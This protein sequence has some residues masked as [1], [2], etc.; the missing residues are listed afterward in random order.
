M[1]H[2]LLLTTVMIVAFLIFFFIAESL[3]LAILTDPMPLLSRGGLIAGLAG[4]GLLVADVV[5][6]VPSSLIMIAHGALFGIVIGTLVSTLGS[7]AATAFGFWLG[8]TGSSWLERLIPEEERRRGN[9]LLQQ[10]GDL[11]IL[12]TRPVPI[13][14]ETTAILA[15]TS[16]MTW[17][18]LIIATLLGAL[19]GT[20]LY[21]IT[22]AT[23][24][25]LDN[26]IYIFA[27]VLAV[28]GLFWLIGKRLR[29]VEQVQVAIEQ[30]RIPNS[31]SD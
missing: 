21:A 15:G 30:Q 11:A 20:L 22:G 9:A 3:G 2:Y 26:S 14:A 28:A 6:P 31:R 24:A 10:W 5:L 12:V 4:F 13:L 18:R 23:A 27:L 1:K 16:Q 8:R 7:L 17:S 25:S 19:P 29:S